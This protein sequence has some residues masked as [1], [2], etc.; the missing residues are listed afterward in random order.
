MPRGA[1]KYGWESS[2]PLAPRAG[3][4]GPGSLLGFRLQRP[5]PPL[6][7]QVTAPAEGGAHRGRGLHLSR[8]PATAESGPQAPPTRT[9]APGCLQG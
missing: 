1:P 9:T 7:P 6:L 4:R 8:P 2:A 3:E 5:W